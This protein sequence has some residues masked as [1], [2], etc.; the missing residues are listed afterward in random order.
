MR[1]H[2]AVKNGRY[3]PVISIKDPATNK[4]KRKWL[5]GHRTKREAEKARAEAITQA[6]NGWL[7]LPSRE[8]VAGLFRKYFDTTGNNKVRK[9][10]LQSYKSMIETHL[11]S[12]LGAK[13][14]SALTP[15]DLNLMMSQMIK[16]GKSATTVR[17]VLR[18]IHL[19][20]GDAVKKGKLTRNVADLADPPRAQPYEHKVWNED[21][22]DRFLTAVATSEYS[23]YFALLATTALTGG[24]RGE[25][26]GLKWSDVDL[27]KDSPKLHIRRTVYKLDNGEW[28]IEPPKTERSRRVIDMPFS[29]MLLLRQLREHQ[30]ANAEWTGRRLSED[31]FV[32]IRTD[33]TL[34]DPRYVSKIFRRIVEGAG[35]KRIRLHELRHTCATLL[36]KHGRSIEEISNLLGHAS[37][38]VTVTIY[39]HW[40]G[41]SR[42]VA[43]TMDSI[44]EKAEK[45]RNK[46][47]FVRNSLE[48]GEGVERR[49]YRSRTCDT[50]IKSQVLCQLS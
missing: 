13:S 41:E 32:F 48:E 46:E 15:D 9:I 27:N 44:L 18:I 38:I 47:R 12:R 34:P 31:D 16:D 37:E 2:I 42:A 6:N 21:E 49:P 39:N 7:N 23:D 40:R 19:V 24:R 4:W 30:E 10:T 22:L 17:Y 28:Q 43:N 26:L 35:L 11:I 33:G 50:L 45:N 36:R 25:A 20:L 3:Y 8:T 1:G 29:L 14:I 5:P